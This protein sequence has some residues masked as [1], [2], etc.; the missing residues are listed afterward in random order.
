VN[1]FELAQNGLGLQEGAHVIFHTTMGLFFAAS[2]FN[3]LTNPAR[4]K[5]LIETFER[6]RVPFVKFNQWWVPGWELA[7]GGLL[8]SGFFPA[9]AAFVLFV[10]CAVA[11]LCEGPT[12]VREYQPINV[13]DTAADWLYLPEVLYGIILFAIMLGV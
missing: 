2:G 13:A 9:A 5:A 12:R 10:I 1:I 8:F 6:D 3:K 11:A 4:H 7:A